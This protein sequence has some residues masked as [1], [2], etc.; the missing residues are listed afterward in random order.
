VAR[1]AW[2]D[3]SPAYRARLVRKG[4]TEESHKAGASLSQARGHKSRAEEN[5][6]RR[7]LRQIDKYVERYGKEYSLTAKGKQVLKDHLRAH[8]TADAIDHMW[9]QES[10][11][12][13]FMAGHLQQAGAAW[14]L[15]EKDAPEWMFWYH[16]PFRY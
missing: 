12:E 5:E 14:S 10:A 13:L 4:V 16:G 2:D 6:R 8:K 1:K 3:L 7:V 9:I 15:R 11:Y